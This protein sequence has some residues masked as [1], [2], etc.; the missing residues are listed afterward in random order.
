MSRLAGD[1]ARG[2]IEP[3]FRDAE[4][5]GVPADRP[6]LGVSRLQQGAEAAVELGLAAARLARRARGEQPRRQRHDGRRQPLDR[7]RPARAALAKLDGDFR[8]QA[9]EPRRG[10]V[11]RIER[12]SGGPGERRLHQSA[13]LRRTMGEPV[14]GE[15]EHVTDGAGSEA[16]RM[17]SRR[18]H[19]Q[20]ARAFARPRLLVEPVGDFARGEREDLAQAVM[21]VAAD[22]PIVT[23]R[24]RGD[25]LDMDEVVVVRGRRLAVEGK[26]RRSMRQFAATRATDRLFS[27]YFHGAPN[28]RAKCGLTGKYS[29]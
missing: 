24:A 20:R 16:K 19:D 25:L 29:I 7:R 5:G 2:A 8:D 13:A 15:G 12:Q 10:R 14:L 9:R 28:R 21:D 11:G 23:L 26:C 17:H 3:A 18:R 4:R 6:M 1:R 22:L 27:R